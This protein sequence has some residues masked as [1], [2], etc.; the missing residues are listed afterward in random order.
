MI[1]PPKVLCK[2]SAVFWFCDL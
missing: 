2:Y 1:M